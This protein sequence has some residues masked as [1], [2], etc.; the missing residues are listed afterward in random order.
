[1]SDKAVHGGRR[2]AALAGDYIEAR[3]RAW[4]PRVEVAVYTDMGHE[5]ALR[6]LQAREESLGRVVTLLYARD[7]RLVTGA[8][9]NC[10][11]FYCKITL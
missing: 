8:V 3:A 9:I 4:T 11:C 7:V 2:S 1:V 6:H 10:I 5:G